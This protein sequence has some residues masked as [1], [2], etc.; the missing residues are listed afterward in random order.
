MISFVVLFNLLETDS[1]KEVLIKPLTLSNIL[2]IPFV[3]ILYSAFKLCN[4]LF[5]LV[6]GP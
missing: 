2:Y 1:V 5:D 3:N 6:Y 4:K